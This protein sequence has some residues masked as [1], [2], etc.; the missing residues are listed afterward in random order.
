MSTFSSSACVEAHGSIIPHA[1]CSNIGS[2]NE[3]QSS[4]TLPNSRRSTRK[5]KAPDYLKDYHL[6]LL[7]TSGES[8][9][10]SCNSLTQIPHPICSVLSYHRLS[11]PHSRFHANITSIL[12]PRTYAQAAKDPNWVSAMNAEILALERNNTWK[13]V[14]LP[15]GT[16]PIACKWVFKVKYKQDGSLDRFKARLV[17]IGSNT[18]QQQ[19]Q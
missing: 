4:S 5:S 18:W 6:S 17:A 2:H 15:N 11:R 7:S 19:L 12:E 13:L 3:G 1:D 10:Y 9:L 14:D 16:R 8:Q